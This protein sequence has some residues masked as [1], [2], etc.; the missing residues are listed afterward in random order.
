M[1][2]FLITVVFHLQSP[3][4][5]SVS[6]SPSKAKSAPPSTLEPSKSFSTAPSVQSSE[7]P[8]VTVSNT[9]SYASSSVPSKLFSA[10]PSMR[11]SELPSV[12]ESNA[13]SYATSSINPVAPTHRPNE[14]QS[15]NFP[16]RE[17]TIITGN[18]DL[19]P[20]KVDTPKPTLKVT[21]APTFLL[22]TPEP[23]TQI[24]S[25]QPPESKETNAVAFPKLKYVLLTTEGDLSDDAVQNVEKAFYSFLSDELAVYY[26]D[27]FSSLTIDVAG[28]QS[29]TRDIDQRRRRLSEA[30]GTQFLFQG[31]INF[32]G[33]APTESE[34]TEAL[35][36]I[37]EDSNE[38]LVSNI[39]NTGDTE[40][41]D[42]VVVLVETPF[43]TASPSAWTEEF[44]RTPDAIEEAETEP[45]AEARTSIIIVSICG[46][47]ALTM[48]LFVFATRARAP[49]DES[50]ERNVVPV[51]SPRTSPQVLPDNIDIESAE[52]SYAKTSN[53]ENETESGYYLNDNEVST[54]V[55]SVTDWNDYAT[56]DSRRRKTSRVEVV[57]G[58]RSHE[59]I[60]ATWTDDERKTAAELNSMGTRTIEMNDGPVIP[61]TWKASG[62]HVPA[63]LSLGATLPSARSVE[64][65]DSDE[66]SGHGGFFPGICG[67]FPSAR[68]AYRGADAIYNDLDSSVDYSAGSVYDWSHIGTVD[69]PSTTQKG[70][71]QAPDSPVPEIQKT[72]SEDSKDTS[73]L[74]RFISD[75]VWLE[76]KIT[77]ETDAAKVREA[78]ELTLKESDKDADADSY[79]YQCDSFSPRSHSS[80][81]EDATTISSRQISQPMS[82][83]CRDCYVPQG[84]FKI[85]IV[86]TVDGPMI[87]SVDEELLGHLGKGDL[88]IAVDDIDTRTQSA[89][90]VDAMITSKSNLERK[91]TVLQFGGN[92]S[93]C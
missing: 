22:S 47:A 55:S 91:L 18:S 78:V 62:Q 52:A 43:P 40:L 1:M 75:L 42:V 73:S 13:P 45:P 41:L 14:I 3:S 77:D 71:T 4:L 28:Y 7:L 67:S 53:E 8:S 35:V 93:M 17:A 16:S 86:S 63:R 2:S 57:D 38:Y 76:K 92:T 46:I 56:V 80:I 19:T 26:D 68:Q 11:S 39:T 9:P 33:E 27:S 29:V 88:I 58:S 65:S 44:A 82:I 89:A 90:D 70:T 31:D 10:T 54:I 84:E 15:T 83:V 74:N 49:E 61:N 59:D 23:T 50:V 24:L 37:G 5:D 81:E 87:N 34:I 85:E 32:V 6:A 69:A 64:E 25:T 72:L 36:T 30:T 79:S 48:F 60:V 51:K 66:C 21:P 20:S 12:A